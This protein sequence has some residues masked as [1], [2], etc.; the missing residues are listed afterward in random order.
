MTAHDLLSELRAKGVDIK[1][2]GDD[3]LVI[4]APRGTVTD[5]LR[6][7]LSCCHFRGPHHRPR[8]PAAQSLPGLTRL[9]GTDRG[10]RLPQCQEVGLVQ[11]LVFEQQARAAFQHLSLRPQ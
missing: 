8:N 1:T 7:A 11:G 9:L 3:R 5:D 6:T 4:D 10:F 2:S